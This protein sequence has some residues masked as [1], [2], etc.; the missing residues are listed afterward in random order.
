M[1]MHSSLVAVAACLVTFASSAEAQPSRAAWPER[2]GFVLGLGVGL[3]LNTSSAGSDYGGGTHFGIVPPPQLQLGVMAGPKVAILL[4]AYTSVYFADEAHTFDV[5]GP[6]VQ[7]FLG[8]S[9]WVRAGGGMALEGETVS[10]D[11]DEIKTGL[12]FTVAVGAPV[13]K[14]RRSSFDLEL[15]LMFGSVE[16]EEYV[17]RNCGAYDWECWTAD[18]W[19]KLNRH[20]GS[21]AVAFSFNKW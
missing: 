18:P 8:D 14:R 3:G 2:H 11:W 13:I 5:V 16:R 12:G 20:Y 17:D 7:V 6:A 19:Q 10:E 15:R 9:V 1:R 4:G 21:I